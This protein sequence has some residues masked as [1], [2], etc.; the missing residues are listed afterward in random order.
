MI[1][2]QLG[3]RNLT[4]RQANMLRGKKYNASKQSHGGDRRGG[5]SSAQKEHLKTDQALAAEYRVSPAT[6]RRDGEFAQ[7]VDQVARNCGEQARRQILSRDGK[8]TKK[9]VMELAA[10]D[11][12]EQ[13]AAL[14][15]LLRGT[16]RPA[17]AKTITLPAEP[18]TLARAL[19]EKLGRAEAAE[20]HD[21][22][23]AE[24]APGPAPGPDTDPDGP[25]AAG[26]SRGPGRRRR[27]P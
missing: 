10:Q 25:S 22:L 8:L 12:P 11:P 27:R 18:R 3:R 26:S 21:A 17:A 6:I 7:A 5:G 2:Q 20:V 9:Q 19:V 13:R 1:D 16:K 14:E 24:L 4:A 15:Q 23:G